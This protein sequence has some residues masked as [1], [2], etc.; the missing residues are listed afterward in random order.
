MH[1][2]LHLDLERHLNFT[3]KEKARQNQYYLFKTSKRKW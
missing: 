3:R 1:M 2:H